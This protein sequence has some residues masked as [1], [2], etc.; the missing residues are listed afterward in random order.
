MAEWNFFGNYKIIEYAHEEV[1]ERWIKN[2]QNIFSQSNKPCEVKIFIV[3]WI[4]IRQKHCI[5]TQN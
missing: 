1:D 4:G 2:F 5:F 3:L